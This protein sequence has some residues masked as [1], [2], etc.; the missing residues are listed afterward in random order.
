MPVGPTVALQQ[1]LATPVAPDRMVRALFALRGLGGKGSI[2]EAMPAGGFVV[3]ESS[4]ASYVLGLVVRSGR[5]QAV[6]SCREWPG[7]TESGMLRLA[8]AF[9]VEPTPAGSRLRTETR[10][11]GRGA[12]TWVAFRAYWLVVRPFSDLVR[13]R[14]RR[15]ARL[16]ALGVSSTRAAGAVPT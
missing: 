13:R 11:D 4:P 14:G 15:E 7:A 6:A 16:R 12:L 1:L 2:S 5:R 8:A 3:L 9:W 10:V